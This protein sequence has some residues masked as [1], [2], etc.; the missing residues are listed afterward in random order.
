MEPTEVAGADSSNDSVKSPFKSRKFLMSQMLIWL[1]TGA[2][3]LFHYLGISDQI[4]LM[5]LGV[6]VGVGGI[7]HAVNVV[8]KRINGVDQ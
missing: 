2:P 7:Y 1:S 6:Y 5:V 4:T 3:I 8:D